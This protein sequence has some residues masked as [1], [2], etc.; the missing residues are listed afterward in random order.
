MTDDTQFI[1]AFTTF[2][3]EVVETHRQQEA[4]PGELTRIVDAHLGADSVGCAVVTE[5]LTPWRLVDADLVLERM[6]AGGRLIG[7]SA[8]HGHRDSGLR[9]L[10]RGERGQAAPSTADHVT[11]PVG[12]AQERRVVAHGLRLL[13][14]DG[15]PLAVL[16]RSADPEWGREQASIEVIGADPGR[17]DAFLAEVRR[18]MVAES[19]LR[20]QVI[21]FRPETFGSS[22]GGLAFH[23]RPAVTADEVVLP[24]GALER[25]ERHV[26]GMREHRDTLLATGQHLKRGVLL[27]GPPGTGKTHTVRRLLSSAPDT[28]VLL[29]SGSA[30]HLVGEAARLARAL[31]PAIVVL[32]DC[33]LVAEDRDMSGSSDSGLF[34]LLEALDGLDGDADVA[35]VLTTNRPDLLER[36]LT[37][38]P[39]RIDLAVEV[40]RPDVVARRALFALYARDLGLSAQ[41]TD[42]AAERAEGVTAS[43]AKELMRRT[44]LT[45]AADGAVVGDDHLVRAL[46]EM[47]GDNEAFTRSLL[48]SGP[49]AF[50]A[51]DQRQPSLPDDG[52]S[53]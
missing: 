11:M 1:E 13:T 23:E 17:V 8:P 2:L 16:Q 27:Y 6:S 29:L 51:G 37:Q 20:G 24:S 45:A 7:L 36:A 35:F 21:S 19:V 39:G 49:S 43:F 48:A 28:T 42:R 40:P 12:P 5:T 22:L 10:L 9:A 41:A 46:E 30:L 44:V 18:R 38:R 50:Q 33:D 14:Y 31:E 34:E 52:W 53:D 25:L 26:L 15:A 47:L 3:R 4:G 32:E